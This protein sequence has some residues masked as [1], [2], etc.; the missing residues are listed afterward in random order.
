MLSLLPKHD[1]AWEQF[2]ANQVTR[3]Q[4]GRKATL[5]LSNLG[6]GWDQSRQQQQN[7]AAAAA[8]VMGFVVKDG[9]FSQSSGVTASALT[10]NVATANGVMTVTTTWQKAAFHGKERGEMFVSEFKRIVLE[11]I[12]HGR[13]EYLFRDATIRAT[14]G[15]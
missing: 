1:G 10:M 11:A 13:D 15:A 12:E 7:E 9:V 8:A 5:K 4:H 14:R 3:D 6:R 2:M